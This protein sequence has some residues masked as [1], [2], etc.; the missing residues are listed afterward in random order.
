MAK[1]ETSL[2]SHCFTHYDSDDMYIIEKNCW[3]D[4]PSHGSYQMFYCEDCTKKT[5][6]TRFQ[7]GIIRKPVVKK[8][9]QKKQ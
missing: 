3:G 9:K 1:K 8:V 7:S 5:K 6:G 4:D 2:C